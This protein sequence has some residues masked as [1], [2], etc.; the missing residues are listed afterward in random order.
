M[1][2]NNKLVSMSCL[3]KCQKTLEIRKYQEFSKLQRIIVYCLDVFPKWKNTSKN[4][5][6]HRNWTFPVGR[7]FAWKL[8]FASNI[9]WMIEKGSYSNINARN[10]QILNNP[11]K[12]MDCLKVVVFQGFCRSLLGF[13]I[14]TLTNVSVF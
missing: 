10:S 11:W 1:I 6:K 12:S 5:M 13:S 8:D 9:L 2:F 14:V 7:Y 4:L 3:R